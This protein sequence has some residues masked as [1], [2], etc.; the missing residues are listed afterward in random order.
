MRKGSMGWDRGRL[1][2]AKQKGLGFMMFDDL[3]SLLERGQ[4]AT[5]K[6]IRLGPINFPLNSQFKNQSVTHPLTG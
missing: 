2:T 5:R 6:M 4:F 1:K 3:R